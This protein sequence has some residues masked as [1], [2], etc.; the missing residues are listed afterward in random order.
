MAFETHCPEPHAL[1]LRKDFHLVYGQQHEELPPQIE[2]I[3]Q[4]QDREPSSDQKSAWR[5]CG[6][7]VSSTKRQMPWRDYD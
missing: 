1:T 3:E 4:A 7:D 6:V 5:L 2:D